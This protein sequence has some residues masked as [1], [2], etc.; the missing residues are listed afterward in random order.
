MQKTSANFLPQVNQMNT[1][2]PMMNNMQIN[3]S[4][5]N[6]YHNMQNLANIKNLQNM[7]NIQNMQNMQRLP[8]MPNLPFNQIRMPTMQSIPSMQSSTA[9]IVDP[10]RQSVIYPKDN[11]LN[12]SESKV[13]EM[14]KEE[15]LRIEIGKGE[16]VRIL[17]ESGF[18]EIEGAELP[19][20]YVLTF[21]YTK[22]AIF[23]WT[24][25]R[26]KVEGN[27]QSIY[28]SDSNKN[29][30]NQYLMVHNLVNEKRNECLIK[31]KVGPKIMI[32][33]S[34]YSGKSTLC[35]ILLNY[36]LK[37]G[38][39]PLYVDLDLSNEIGVP[40]T[41]SACPVDFIIPNEFMI[42]SAIT[43]FNGNTINNINLHLYEKQINE[44]ASLV[45]GKLDC[46]LNYFKKK[47]NLEGDSKIF[48][49]DEEKINFSPTPGDGE[50]NQLFVNCE[51]P[52]LFASGAIIHCPMIS[53]SRDNLIF[54]T[55]IEE[56][57]VDMVFVIENE[58]LFNVIK[59]INDKYFSQK[60]ISVNL[61]YKTQG[62]NQ[63]PSYKE[64]LEQK[65]FD[66][67]FKGPF[68]NLKITEFKIDLN[69][70]KL[71]Q[72]IFSNVTSALLP[73]GSTSDLNI[74]LREV[75]LEENLLNRVVSIVHLEEK[76]INDLDQNY[77]KKLNTYV[78]QFAR[79]PVQFLAYM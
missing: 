49:S 17:V 75:N 8:N 74:L 14:Q 67:Y 29:T 34:S 48:Y 70:Y 15:E 13:Y 21:T 53:A 73:I 76:V 52:T 78:E 58:K 46:D 77:D 4:N 36:A 7:Q 62:I 66:S 50:N 43:L 44:L 30:M 79:A 42:D 47:Y 6:A 40:G 37:L 12:E 16:T 68:T 5:M 31:N 24:E 10:P 63:D 41:I 3:L 72:I 28:P 26:I 19:L 60:N 57:D 54:K 27:P 69:Q 61:L 51:H 11:F 64:Y 23:C 18:V 71:L 56:F 20:N 33:G 38:W 9:T 55:F 35:H 32:T 2:I 22:F 65:R 39:T 59:S 45:N 1:M 25:A